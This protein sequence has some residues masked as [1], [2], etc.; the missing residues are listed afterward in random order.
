MNNILFAAGTVRASGA[1]TLSGEDQISILRAIPVMYPWLRYEVDYKWKMNI[2]PFKTESRKFYANN[3]RYAVET[4]TVIVRQNYYY[5]FSV[6]TVAKTIT[7]G[8]RNSFLSMMMF[9]DFDN[10]MIRENITLRSYAIDS[11]SLRKLVIDFKPS[12]SWEK[13]IVIYDPLTLL[14][15]QIKIIMKAT[16][17]A[18]QRADNEYI[19]DF[20]NYQTTPFDESV[21][22]NETWF[23]RQ[24]DALV[25]KEAYSDYKLINIPV[26][27][28]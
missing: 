11:G 27:N 24:E 28:K 13:Y 10:R 7:T 23:T 2:Q 6:D 18:G 4:P 26:R 25:L 17:S 19:I 8:E 14:P 1:D 21:F 12:S 9:F 22:S 15:K 3:G 16:N 5:N 20:R